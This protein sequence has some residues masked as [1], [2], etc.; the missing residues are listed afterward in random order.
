VSERDRFRVSG[1]ELKI[2]GAFQIQGRERK[3]AS[4][5]VCE[6]LAL[7]TKE[8]TEEREDEGGSKKEERQRG[9]DQG[10]GRMERERHRQRQR[11]REDGY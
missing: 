2:R 11:D 10:E 9:G 4:R 1:S 3:Q 5:K 7:R 6:N 8:N